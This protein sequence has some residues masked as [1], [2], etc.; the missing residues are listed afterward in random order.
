MSFLKTTIIAF[1]ST[2]TLPLGPEKKYLFIVL[3]KT[4]YIFNIQFNKNC[5][6]P[7]LQSIAWEEKQKK[8][9]QENIFEG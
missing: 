8:S 6:I 3:R 2:E 4:F 1:Y 5:T 7:L 9:C